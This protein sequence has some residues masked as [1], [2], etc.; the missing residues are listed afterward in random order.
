MPEPQTQQKKMSEAE[1]AAFL[2]K[3]IPS[4][5][6][7]PDAQLV[8]GVLS[9][10]PDLK[11]R[12]M[13]N[14]PTEAEQAASV[15]TMGQAQNVPKQ[16]M[17][18]V[19]EYG[20]PEAKE[21]LQDFYKGVMEVR[22][23]NPEFM[24][25]SPAPEGPR[26]PGFFRNLLWEEPKSILKS[27]ASNPN[28]FAGYE[29]PNLQPVVN[30]MESA[31]KGDL[32][33]VLTGAA[34]AVPIVGGPASARME[35]AKTDP[36]GAAGATFTD[37]AALALP[38][39]LGGDT[40]MEPVMVDQ[41]TKQ[42]AETM[43][44]EDLSPAQFSQHLQSGFDQIADSAGK[45]KEGVMAQ[46]ER[47]APS[48]KVTYPKT[49]GVLRMYVDNLKDM[50]E[51]NPMLFTQQEALNKTLTILEQELKSTQAEASSMEHP[52][53]PSNMRKADLRRNQ[54]FLYRQQLDPSLASRV[55][56]ALNKALADDVGSAVRQV[57]EGLAD[58]YIASSNRYR[59]IQDIARAKTFKQIFGDKRISPDKVVAVLSQNPEDA[60]RAVRTLYEGN[61]QA[62]G[63]LRRSL[64][65]YGMNKGS[66]P[67]LQPSVI[68][69]VFGP[70]S[71]A[72]QD[73]IKATN[74][75]SA[76]ANPILAKLPGKMGATAR[77]VIAATKNSPA[78]YINGEEL[79]KILKSSNAVRLATQAAGMSSAAPPAASVRSML[80]RLLPA[81]G[82]I[83]EKEEEKPQ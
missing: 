43:A 46:I 30:A 47:D 8:Q 61:D 83:N 77:F 54:Y 15:D 39:A 2:K 37:V 40:K 28:S 82:V 50:K 19:S 64:F 58:R 35:Q 27:A 67:K 60:L 11:D 68:R 52:S 5:S 62:I 69:E 81:M 57:N 23:K 17:K 33:G 3:Q 55:T 80:V 32:G 9:R 79:S 20:S 56:G 22:K 24:G 29:P 76:P 51:R 12:I 38:F 14:R 16:L 1:F 7:Y 49:I 10:R 25:G 65:E 4:L 75:L 66:L 36:W 13:I 74:P 53:S 31:K 71:E 59:Q 70:H 21:D 48:V 42:L 44:K 73:F 26:P 63:A 6:K 72:V 18:D 78:I 45:Q 41:A 34:G